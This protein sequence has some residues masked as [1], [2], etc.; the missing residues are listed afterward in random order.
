MKQKLLIVT[1]NPMKFRELGSRLGEFFDCEMVSFDEPEIQGTAEEISLH[2]MKRAYEVFKQP[3]LVDDTSVHLGDLNGFPG[4]YMKD[5]FK[6][7]SPY[8]IGIKFAGST[9]KAVCRLGLMRGEDDFIVAEGVINGTVIPPKNN[10][11]KD[12]HF[13][14]FLQLDGTNKPLI[15]FSDEEKNKISHRGK[16][17]DNLIEL[18]KKLS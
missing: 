8:E 10:D 5:M 18:V 14:L 15:E 17:M 3:V 16:A 7:M 13:D 11:F 1:S 12:R 4:P 2:K 6:Y 9:M